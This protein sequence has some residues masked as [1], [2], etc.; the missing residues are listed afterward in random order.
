MIQTFNEFITE[1]LEISKID[2]FDI[3]DEILDMIPDN[4]LYH[5]SNDISWFNSISD[6]NTIS[7]T[8]NAES[9]YLFLSPTK[10][11]AL[12]YSITSVGMKI[13]IS[14]TSGVL[15]FSLKKGKKKKLSY[16]DV[17]IISDH[18]KFEAMLDEYKENGYDYVILPDGN[19]HAI[20][21]N[22]ILKYLGSFYNII[23]QILN[24]FSW[25][26]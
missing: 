21:N 9:K 24:S 11:V 26:S 4:K 15:V 16:N 6:I 20:L 7:S 18:Q 25:F 5:G 14:D 10:T 19:N 12:N 1:N 8:K 23:K 2:F 3:E 22:D 13:N 17:K